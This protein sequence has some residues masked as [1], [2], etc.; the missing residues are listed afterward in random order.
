[1]VKSIDFERFKK[2]VIKTMLSGFYYVKSVD[3]EDFIVF[4]YKHHSGSE[5]LYKMNSDLLNTGACTTTWGEGVSNR[6]IG[7]V[8]R[9][10]YVSIFRYLLDSDNDYPKYK[11]KLWYK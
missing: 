1:M 11:N 3:G 5:Y 8:E 6:I 10:R 4:K 2:N 7:K 9:D